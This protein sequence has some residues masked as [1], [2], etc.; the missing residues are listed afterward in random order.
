MHLYLFQHLKVHDQKN[1]KLF[2]SSGLLR[3]VTRFETD[4]SGLH[5]DPP[6]RVFLDIL[7]LAYETCRYFRNVGLKPPHAA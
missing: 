2:L 1:D 4:V 5:V 3:G 6:W 7:T